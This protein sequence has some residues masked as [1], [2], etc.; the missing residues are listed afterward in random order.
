LSHHLQILVVG[1]IIL[2]F[3]GIGVG[4]YKFNPKKH[5]S[6]GQP[7][8][9]PSEVPTLT[10][11]PDSCVKANTQES[12]LLTEAR[13]I[14]LKSECFQQGGLTGKSIC[15]D[16]TGTWWLDLDIEKPGCA[17]ACVV[18]VVTKKAEINWQCTGLIPEKRYTCPENN[19]VDCMPLIQGEKEWFCS[20]EYLGWARENCPEFIIAY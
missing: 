11:G 14:A 9:T 19:T 8:V 3:L 16:Y 2:V 6:T 4:V 15:N 18:D 1:I 12:M 10:P 5:L 17:P 13:E 20:E 7:G